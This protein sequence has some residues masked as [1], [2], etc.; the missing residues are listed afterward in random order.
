MKILYFVRIVYTQ[1]FLGKCRN[2]KK[3]GMGDSFL[4]PEL[5]PSS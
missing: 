1:T 3:K 2:F 5:P 4:T